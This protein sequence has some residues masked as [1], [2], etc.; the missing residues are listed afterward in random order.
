[1]TSSGWGWP[2]NSRKRHYFQK[3]GISL[4]GKWMYFGEKKEGFDNSD[5]NCKPCRL[6]LAKLRRKREQK[7]K[8]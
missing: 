6:K 5:E 3:K 2:L 4:C 8:Q 1:M 7:E